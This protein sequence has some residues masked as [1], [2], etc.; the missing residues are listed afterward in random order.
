VFQAP[1]RRQH[2]MTHRFTVV[3][4]LYK[5]IKLRNCAQ[6]KISRIVVCVC[7]RDASG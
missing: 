1:Y 4:V 7:I 6:P 2:I 5:H 3:I